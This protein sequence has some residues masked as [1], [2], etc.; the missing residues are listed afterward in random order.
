[1]WGPPVSGYAATWPALIGQ[2]G[3]CP[4]SLRVWLKG[5]SH[6]AIQH[7]CA[8]VRARPVRSH[9]EVDSPS[10]L[11]HR[12]CNSTPM[13]GAAPSAAQSRQRS[14]VASPL[15]SFHP[16]IPPRRR[17]YDVL[18]TPHPRRSHTTPGHHRS[19]PRSR[20]PPKPEAQAIAIG[21][22]PLFLSPPEPTPAS[23]CH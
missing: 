19:K 14:W 11:H 18:A 15:L 1:M 21:E 4:L 20:P 3:W 8:P 5:G 22:P 2:A 10:A 23:P 6:S 9:A 7:P 17:S 13:S 16:E 12:L